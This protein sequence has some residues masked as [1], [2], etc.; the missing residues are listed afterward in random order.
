MGLPTILPTPIIAKIA[1]Y[2]LTNDYKFYYQHLASR[3]MPNL[4]M[5]GLDRWYHAI[6]WAPIWVDKIV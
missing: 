6:T 3:A 5:L 4:A 1:D 2:G